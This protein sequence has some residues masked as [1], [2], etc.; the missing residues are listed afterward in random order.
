MIKNRQRQN[1]GILLFAQD[2]DERLLRS[3]LFRQRSSLRMTTNSLL[4]M[5][6]KKRVSDR[7]ME[8]DV[9][10]LGV[11]KAGVDTEAAGDGGGFDEDLAA[12]SWDAGDGAVELA[13]AV[14][15]DHGAGGSGLL[16]GAFD[17]GSGDGSAGCG[18]DAHD[19]IGVAEAVLFHTASEDGFVE[20]LGTVH[21][22]TGNLE[23]C[24][25]RC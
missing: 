22:G 18:E 23:P 7:G 3:S 20:A 17:E 19:I 13:V 10:A 21:I 8:A 4:R 2:D 12:G 9:V 14:E 1:A 25:C 5:T 6:T 15:V 11:L 16:E 24:C